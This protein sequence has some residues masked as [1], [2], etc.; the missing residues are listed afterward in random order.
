MSQAKKIA[1]YVLTRLEHLIINVDPEDGV[2]FEYSGSD[3]KE[4]ALLAMEYT[5][6][7]SE[8]RHVLKDSDKTLYSEALEIVEDEYVKRWM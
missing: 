1:D 8:H 5:L 7:G 6:S 2:G 4:A 3:P